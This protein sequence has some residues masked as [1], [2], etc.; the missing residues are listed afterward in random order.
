MNT[1]FTQT[2]VLTYEP[3]EEGTIDV[4]LAEMDN[5]F[6]NSHDSA[7][8]IMDFP[9]WLSFFTFDVISNLTYSKRHGFITRG[10]DVYGI[11]GWVIKFIK[12]DFFV[13]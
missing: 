9:T 8:S 11:K 6:V 10:E 5:R 2:A 4:F 13:S 12:Y 1:F 7:E 3:F